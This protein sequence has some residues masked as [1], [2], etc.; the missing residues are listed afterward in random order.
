MRVVSTMIFK[1]Q[2]SIIL[3]CSI[4]TELTLPRLISYL[5]GG[6]LA[7]HREKGPFHEELVYFLK[8]AGDRGISLLCFFEVEVI[9]KSKMACIWMTI[10][11]YWT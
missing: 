2:N 6:K 11:I 9:W 7:F 5:C 4:M 8:M 1:G 3:I 10:V